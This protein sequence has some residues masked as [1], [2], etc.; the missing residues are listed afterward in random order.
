V[1]TPHERA[2]VIA[3]VYRRWREIEL[4]GQEPTLRGVGREF[5]IAPHTVR[6]YVLIGQQSE[7]WRAAFDRAQISVVVH[8]A[9][10]ELL[11]DALQDARE[12][13]AHKDRAAH[14]NT[15][16]AAISQVRRMH[17]LDMPIRAHVTSE[18]HADPALVEEVSQQIRVLQQRERDRALDPARDEE[19]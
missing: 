15:A 9:L 7:Q 2:D 6:R 3:A 5:A 1:G 18:V 17:G 12:A 11:E 19:D 13:V 4:T 16:L 14:R 10:S 8:E